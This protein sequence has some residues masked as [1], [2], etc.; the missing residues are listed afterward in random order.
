MHDGELK[1][2]DLTDRILGTFFD[3]YNEL[4]PGFLESVYEEAMFIALTEAGLEVRRQVPVPVHFRGR[5]IGEY[6]ADLMVQNVVFVE[7]KVA[8]ALVQAHYAQLVHYLRATQLE[9]GL[10]LNFGPKPDFKR[11]A[12]SNE[13]KKIRL[14][15]FKSAVSS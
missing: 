8:E 3:V 14:N 2:A 7:L 6:R 4:G 15:R 12:V 13:S 10:L 9:V 11:I 5:V 1:H